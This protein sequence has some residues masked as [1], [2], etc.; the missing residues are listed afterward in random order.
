MTHSNPNPTPRNGSPIKLKRTTNLSAHTAK[1]ATTNL[2]WVYLNHPGGGWPTTT[3]CEIWGL[4]STAPCTGEL[5][6][7][8]GERMNLRKSGARGRNP[9]LGLQNFLN[10]QQEKRKLASETH[11]SSPPSEI[12]GNCRSRTPKEYTVRTQI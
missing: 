1:Q 6:I 5:A 7:R 11:W 4:K 3:T 10:H 8:V 12:K 9:Y 2:R